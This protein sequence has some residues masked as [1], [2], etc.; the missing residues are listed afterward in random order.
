MIERIFFSFLN[1]TQTTQIAIILKPNADFNSFQKLT[2]VPLNGKNYISWL[3]A[4]R[5]SLKSKRLLGYI[6]G[7]RVRSN[8]G[9]EA[10]DE[11]NMMDN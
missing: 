9:A 5:V 10:H 2:N 3:K 7:T 1:Q 6:N 4:A 8:G 11:C